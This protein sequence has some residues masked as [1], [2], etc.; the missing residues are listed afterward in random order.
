M[1]RIA[2]SSEAGGGFLIKFLSASTVDP[3]AGPERRVADEV[4]CGVREKTERTQE[5]G[6]NQWL[7]DSAVS[8]FSLAGQV[9]P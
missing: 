1:G 8:M 3:H 9:T 7:G 5:I 2:P 6:R 4:L